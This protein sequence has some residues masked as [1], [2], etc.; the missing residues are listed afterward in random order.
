MFRDGSRLLA[1]LVL[2]FRD[3]RPLTCFGAL[4]LALLAA[5]LAAGGFVLSDFLRSGGVSNLPLALGSAVLLLLSAVV[6]ACG[7]VL[8]SINRR[9][10]DLAALVRAVADR[11][12]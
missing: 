5:S 10:A 12:R 2:Y 7:V 4:A 11:R 3:L 9:A 6:L 1:A 8:S